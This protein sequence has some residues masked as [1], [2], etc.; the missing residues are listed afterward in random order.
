[1]RY[2]FGESDVYY[3]LNCAENCRMWFAERSIP[4]VFVLTYA[5]P[6]SLNTVIGEPISIPKIEVP[7]RGDVAF[8]HSEYIHALQK[9]FDD[10]KAKYGMK[11][12]TLQIY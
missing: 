7:T 3:V 9:L 6:V 12:R 11:E 4:G 2:T 1:M 8:Y 5:R 10:N